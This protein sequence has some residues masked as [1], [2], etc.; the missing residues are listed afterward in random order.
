MKIWKSMKSFWDF[1]R[2]HPLV[3]T[4]AAVIKD[5]MTRLNQS[6]SKLRGQ[7][8]DGCSTMSGARSGVAKR[9]TDEEPR[10]LFM[11]CYGHSLNLAASDTVKN[12]RLMRNALDT[13][14]E[15]TKLIKFSPRREAIFRELKAEGDLASS[16]R[17]AGIR[18]L[19]PT[20]WTVRADSLFSVISNYSALLSTWDE[21]IEAVKDTES[22]ARI[23]GVKAQ[24][25][26]FDFLFG[27]TLGE[28]VLRHTDNLS[29]TL[30]D[31]SFS[32]AE[33]QQVANMV[34]VTLQ[35]LRDVDSF[36]L[37][38]NKVT[39]SAESLEAEEPQLPRRRKLPRRY[40]EGTSESEFHTDS[41]AFYRQHYY[42]IIDLI[43]N[44]IQARFE[45]PGYAVY[46]NLEQLLVKASLGED[47]SSELQEVCSFYKDDFQKELL[48]AQLETFRIDFQ[49]A[50]KESA[51]SHLIKTP[52]IFDI[53]D[54]FTSLSAAQKSLL[55]QVCNALKIIL[56]MPATNSTSERSFS[57]LR[58]V[59][60]YVRSTMTQQRLNN[61][62]VLQDITDSMNL[63][64]IANEFVGNSEHRLR[65]FG[66]FK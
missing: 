59:K 15:I 26:T 62:M 66:Y 53:K 3:P 13:T 58:R 8:Y 55:S 48:Q 42:E 14:H 30:Q 57:A 50:Q 19:C 16:Y 43:V 39:T 29:K 54:Y 10:A 28:M 45:Q 31:K 47:I 61:L 34:L 44:C 11:H 4:L 37:F 60:T 51:G 46:R 56:V 21:A 38:W 40:D 63:K 36:D 27:V 1:T 33:G 2:L 25:K 23:Q 20:R 49:R 17:A 52:T 35:A 7:C 22:K 65:I 9:I 64:N 5:I 24:M 18:V 41:K 6:M 32:A 12:S